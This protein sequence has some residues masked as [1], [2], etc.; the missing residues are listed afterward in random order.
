MNA[1]ATLPIDPSSE[2]PALLMAASRRLAEAKTAGEVL[3]ARE[4]AR[5]A[6]DAASAALRIAKIRQ[7]KDEVISAVNHAQ[8]DAMEI[9]YKAQRRFAE[10]YD[11]AQ[12]Q[13]FVAGQGNVQNADVSHLADLGVTRQDV[14]RF[15]E[16]AAAET[17]E[18]GITRRVLDDQ[19]AS[20]QSPNRAGL[21]RAFKEITRGGTHVVS[22]RDRPDHQDKDAKSGEAIVKACVDIANRLDIL[23]LER[24]AEAISEHDHGGRDLTSIRNAHTALG[25]LLEVCDG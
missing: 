25:K 14:H 5:L 16:A 22:K 21:L 11:E 19:L 18:P 8:A 2:L 17:A 13:G 1:V 6:Q 24:I 7:A 15:R 3:E 9:E 4:M 12:K 10:E 20:E 23:G